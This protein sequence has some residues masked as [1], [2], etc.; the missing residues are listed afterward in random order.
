MFMSFLE[1]PLHT[2]LLA[3]E[4][5]AVI[6]LR[7]RKIAGGGPAAMAEASQM[8]TEKVSALAEAAGTL[9]TGGSLHTVVGRYRLYV[10]ANEMRLLG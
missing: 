4:A 2:M 7:M 1:L 6:G 8:V 9:M 10:R 5:H 3:M